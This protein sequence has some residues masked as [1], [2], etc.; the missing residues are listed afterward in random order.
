MGRSHYSDAERNG[1]MFDELDIAREYLAL[2]D[3]RDLTRVERL[4]AEDVKLSLNGVSYPPGREP[5]IRRL[6]AL[7]EG[8]PD[9]RVEVADVVADGERVAIRY[10]VSGTQTGPL[11]LPA[12]E[13]PAATRHF[14]Y[15]VA[16]FL[17]IEDGQ[18]VAA[19]SVS[20]FM[21]ALRRP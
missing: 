16:A 2:L 3:T 13:I 1:R 12:A 15:S 8:A 20:D 6:A 7:V 19:D 9:F 10:T 5:L 21:S 18:V 11:H 17:T 4:V 14:R